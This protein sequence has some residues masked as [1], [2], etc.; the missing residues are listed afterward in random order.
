[1]CQM[2]LRAQIWLENAFYD[3]QQSRKIW[4]VKL[5]FKDFQVDNQTF[6]HQQEA[7]SKLLKKCVRKFGK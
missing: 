2:C 3:T 1:M 7:C 5:Y 4:I 6:S